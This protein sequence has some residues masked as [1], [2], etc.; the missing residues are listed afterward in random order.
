MN[1]KILELRFM[2][3]S[4]EAYDLFRGQRPFKIV[5]WENGIKKIKFVNDKKD[6]L[7]NTNDFYFTQ[8]KVDNIGFI[9]YYQKK[10]GEACEFNEE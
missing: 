2:D 5:I 8:I 9:K 10:G 3:N 6:V 4:F 7:R 1:N